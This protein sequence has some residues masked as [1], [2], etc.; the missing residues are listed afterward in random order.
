[1]LPIAVEQRDVN[2]PAEVVVFERDVVGFMQ[3]VGVKNHR[4]IGSIG[5]ANRLGS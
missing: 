5:D 1:M 4:A 3:E 2:A